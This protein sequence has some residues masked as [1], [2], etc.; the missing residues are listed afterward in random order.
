M[1]LH[2]FYV[3]FRAVTPL[4]LIMSIGYFIKKRGMLDQH[5]V[6]KINRMAFNVMFPCMIFNAMYQSNYSEE[7]NYKL[8][9]LTVLLFFLSLGLGGLI[10]RHVKGDA[11]L[12]G[13]MLQIIIRGNYMVLGFPALISLYGSES[14]SRAAILVVIMIPLTNVFTVV[15]L[16]IF[17]QQRITIKETALDV[18]KN[19]QIIA[20]M[21]GI[22]AV[23][24][25]WRVPTFIESTI[26]YLSG[27]GTPVALLTLGAAMDFRDIKKA[28][29][30]LF[31]CTAV[32]L[33][34]IPGIGMFIGALLGIRGIDFM[35][36]ITFFACGAPTA[37]YTMA[38][39][40]ESDAEFTASSVA[41]TSALCPFSMFLLIFI[42]K[43]IGML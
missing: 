15:E 30:N 16:D 3:S 41:I 20:S 31:L 26:S 43:T 32:R 28:K 37:C 25:Q 22:I 23:L 4:L 40:M 27:A 39:I 7:I 29:W 38:M 34:V 10:L 36:I 42:S 13:A 21:L 9:V 1:V 6:K 11:K 18:F 12:K 5:D 2:N 19:P 24:F 14:I 17:K 35:L 33:L 8:V